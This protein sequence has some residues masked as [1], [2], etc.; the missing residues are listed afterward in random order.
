M[1]LII[2]LNYWLNENRVTFFWRIVH[3]PF[4]NSTNQVPLTLSFRFHNASTYNIYKEKNK[5]KWKMFS[6]IYLQC[7]DYM[8]LQFYSDK[9]ELCLAK[10]FI[11]ICIKTSYV[12]IQGVSS[13]KKRNYERHNILTSSF[14]HFGETVKSNLPTPVYY[15]LCHKKAHQISSYVISMPTRIIFTDDETKS[16][17]RIWSIIIL[18]C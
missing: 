2:N 18:R 15:M 17:L 7:A 13:K 5:S 4:I 16:G 12:A 14:T 8:M 6:F 10:S 1:G 11:C 3:W 9:L